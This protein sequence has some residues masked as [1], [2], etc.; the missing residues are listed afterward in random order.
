MIPA[1][2]AL[3]LDRLEKQVQLVLKE[4]RARIAM[5]QVQQ[6]LKEFKVLPVQ[7]EVLALKV[8]QALKV[9]RVLKE[10]LAP[11]VP[12]AL[13]ALK[14]FKVHRGLKVSL[15]QLD[16]KELPEQ[17]DRLVLKEPKGFKDLKVFKVFKV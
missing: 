1:L 11:P 10:M 5:F 16:Q 13:K 3:F 7:P 6:V 8:N 15:A 14:V 12:K 9:R 2:I 17:L 4:I